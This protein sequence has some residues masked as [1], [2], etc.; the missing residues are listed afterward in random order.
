MD[1]NFTTQEC[2]TCAVTS[3]QITYK[4]ANVNFDRIIYEHQLFEFYDS[5]GSFE[6]RSITAKKECN[7]ILHPLVCMAEFDQNA[8]R[9]A[10]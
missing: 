4:E 1:N 7:K 9:G 6:F 5:R 2:I 10:I 3:S 8:A